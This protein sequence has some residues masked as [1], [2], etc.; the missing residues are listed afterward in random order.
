[1]KIATHNVEFLFGEGEHTFQ[2][3]KWNFTKEYVEGRIEYLANLYSKID[4]DILFL[5]E[6][7]SEDV[8]KRII[9]KVGKDYSYFLATPDRSGV[10]NAVLYKSQ[11]C[12]CDSIPTTSAMP[13]FMEGDIDTLGPR[14]PSRRD[15]VKVTTTYKGNPLY[16]FGLHL[17]AK[18]LVPLKDSNKIDHAIETQVDAADAFI[19]SEMFTLAQA[20]KMREVVDQALA[21]DPKS[22]VIVAGDFNAVEKDASFRIVRGELKDRSDSLISLSG[23]IPRSD[24]FSFCRSNGE[25]I[26]IDHILFSKNLEPH[27]KSLQILNSGLSRHDYISPN[28]S[29]VESDHAPVVLELE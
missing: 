3:K 6:V 18:F 12:V 17:K 4:A 15:F 1:M 11:D 8:I 24:C 14:I 27:A 5:Q 23:K 16:L 20:R 29:F 28:R 26:Y 7:A 22:A 25:K 19:R 21:S 10:G 13:V 2:G 9:A